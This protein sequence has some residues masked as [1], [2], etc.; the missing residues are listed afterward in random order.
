MRRPLPVQVEPLSPQRWAKIERSL[1]SRLEA[2]SPSDTSSHGESRRP[3]GRR[4]LLGLVAASLTLVVVAVL[5]IAPWRAT[6]GPS[7]VEHASRITTGAIGS[8]LVL[9]ELTLDVD[10][11]STVVIGAAT[12]RGMLLVL[13]RGSIV[14]DV[15]PRSARAPMIIQAGA[16]QIRVVGTRFRVE[17]HG[18]AAKVA[19]EHGLV[20]VSL[21]GHVTRVAAGQVWPPA[22]PAPATSA[23]SGADTDTAERLDALGPSGLSDPRATRHPSARPRTATSA[24]PKEEPLPS[25][26]AQARFEQAA[27]LERADPAQAT[28]IYQ[29][30]ESGSDSWA[31]NSLYAHGRLEAAR[32]NTARARQLLERYMARFPKGANGDDARALLERLR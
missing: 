15:T 18:E 17:R 32:G 31:Q 4:A 21:N 25:L 13:D 5:L 6:D 11:E 9:R 10:P 14:C 12:E 3:W 26:S 22:A 23:T 19:V 24:P 16:A 27:R 20:E 1:F 30:L 8:H 29:A 7:G 2:E 28:A